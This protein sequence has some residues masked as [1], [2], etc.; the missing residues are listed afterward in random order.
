MKNIFKLGSI[1]LLL[2]VFVLLNCCKD[3]DEPINSGHIIFKF[4]YKIDGDSIK[5]DKLIYNN[6]AGNNYEVTNIQWFISDICFYKKGKVE[7]MIHK[8]DDAFYLDTDIP[9]T[10]TLN[11]TDDVPEGNYDSI[12]F[13]FG[14]T[15]EKNISYRFSNLP[16]S[17]MFWPDMLGGGYHYM[18]L[19][20]FWIDTVG[21][22]RGFNFHLGIGKRITGSD[23]TFEQ[24]YFTVNAANSAFNLAKD[25][26]KVV[27]IVMN[28][29]EW[30]KNPYVFDWNYWGGFI[31]EIPDAMVMGRENGKKGVFTIGYITDL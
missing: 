18:K 21:F 24:N 16:E 3:K 7:Y 4:A 9:S 8:L 30:F 26:T 13:V 6:A 25:K 22:R 28:V 12:S 29:D 23:T 31:M 15:K 19:N 11:F 1:I 20:G 27:Q 5:Y 2:P 17:A 14:I 10:Y